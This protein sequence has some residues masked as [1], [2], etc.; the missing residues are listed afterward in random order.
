MDEQITT[1]RSALSVSEAMKMAITEAQKGAPFVSPNPLVGCVILDSQGKFLSSGYHKIYGGPHAEV[2]ALAGLSLAQL[3]G[4]HVIVTLEPCAHQ[5]KTPSCAKALAALPIKKVTYGLMDPNPLV[6]GQGAEILKAAGKEVE[7][8]GELQTELQTELEEVCEIF[9]LNQREKKIFIALKVATSLDGQMALK[10]GESQWITGEKARE[11]SHFLRSCYDAVL[12]GAGTVRQD[13]PS[14]NIRHPEVKK[15]NKVIVL[16]PKG[17]ELNNF[18]QLRLAQT[19]L[20]ENIYWC[21]GQEV[22]PPTLAAG[23]QILKI[24]SNEKGFHLDHLMS[25]L[26]NQ[27]IRSLFV[28]GG[29]QTFAALLQSGW[30]HRLYLYQAPHLIGAG[31]GLA[32][33]QGLTISKMNERKTLKNMRFEKLGEDFFLTGRFPD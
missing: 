23:P 21:I 3:Q 14:L 2:N 7:L 22:K 17:S 18:S 19:H 9:L 32:W 5:G 16:D 20:R 13:N 8:F 28:E 33:T 25:E 30:A 31:G 27:G 1:P 11:H 29:A 10:S 6:A 15:E 26:W 24:K 4:A 12:V